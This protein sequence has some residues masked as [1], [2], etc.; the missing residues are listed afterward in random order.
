M[1]KMK[2]RNTRKPANWRMTVLLQHSTGMK[3]LATGKTSP[4]DPNL[5]GKDKRH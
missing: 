5:H 2:L 4:V 1:Q 3:G